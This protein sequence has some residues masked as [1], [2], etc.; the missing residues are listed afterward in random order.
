MWPLLSSVLVLVVLA[1][2]SPGPVPAMILAALGSLLMTGMTQPGSIRRIAPAVLRDAEGNPKRFAL[3]LDGETVDL[4]PGKP[5]HQVDHFKWVTRGLIDE[6]QSFHV[7]ADGGVDINGETIPL[8]AADAVSR[9]EQEINKRHFVEPATQA[10]APARRIVDVP[11]H[12]PDRVVFRARL[13]ALGHVIVQCFRGPERVETGLR[14][15]AGLVQ[16]ELMIR[17]RSMHVDPLQRHIEIDDVRFEASA[18]G[19]A[20]LEEA[21]NAHYAVSL[22]GGGQHAITIKENA[23]AASGF[24]IRFVG[25]RAGTRL[26]VQGHLSQET[27]DVL[28]DPVKCDLLRPGIVLKM[29][30]PWLLFRR[31]R[32]DSGEEHVSGLADLQYRQSTASQLEKLF[33]HPAIRRSADGPDAAATAEE[34]ANR[35]FVQLHVGRN[36]QTKAFL[37]LTGVPPEG[38]E[39]IGMALTHHNLAE[40]QHRGVF[41]PNLEVRLTLD[42]QTLGVR[43]LDT[44][45][46]QTMRLGNDSSDDDLQRAGRMLTAALRPPRPRAPV[47]VPEPTPAPDAL[48]S[49]AAS[50]VAAIE[51]RATPEPTAAPDPTVAKVEP[52]MTAAAPT[53][54]MGHSSEASPPAVASTASPDPAV[55][56]AAAAAGSEAALPPAGPPS[57]GEENPPDREG[58]PRMD[59]FTET[60]PG[61]VN[62]GVFRGVQARFGLALQDLHLS[63]PRVF[64]DR[65]FEILSLDGGAVDDLFA[66]RSDDFYGFY[67]THVGD[68][69]D[70]V[71]ACGGVHLEFGTQRCVV[72]TSLASEPHDFAGPA[73][74]GLARDGAGEFVFI[75]SPAYRT[76]VAPHERPCAAVYAHFATAREYDA[77]GSGELLWPGPPGAT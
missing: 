12:P 58:P 6:P 16:N 20:R 70:L 14:G 28:Q 57:P 66:L 3:T 55:L 13:D 11:A 32:P 76:W 77:A 1:V 31:R 61:V 73:L 4:D 45:A 44:H 29:S 23:A 10:R 72:Q 48:P 62:A 30:P 36:P 53:A 67:L 26:D 21:L 24:D 42:H 27:L 35:D 65:R 50:P 39:P 34:P 37:W 22:K 25:L 54:L 2:E 43:N 49:V 71:Y 47:P 7:R 41:L 74:L 56:Q 33:N 69:L 52:V 40:L 75:V 64:T 59:P 19:A 46:E 38:G 60:D 15:L 68:D 63:L 5:W 9:L 18:E 8:T 17:P 51:T